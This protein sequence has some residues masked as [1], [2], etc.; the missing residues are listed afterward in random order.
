MSHRS[1]L[2]PAAFPC[3][4]VGPAKGQQGEVVRGPA[5][6]KT[7]NSNKRLSL[8]NVFERRGGTHQ[9]VDPLISQQINHVWRSRRIEKAH[10]GFLRNPTKRR[11]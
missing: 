4:N 11:Q 2:A 10:F 6:G 7:L 9:E 5:W 8:R 3:S 1:A